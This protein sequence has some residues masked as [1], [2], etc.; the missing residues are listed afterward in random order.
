MKHQRPLYSK[1]SCDDKL[2]IY[3]N[4]YLPKNNYEYRKIL[5]NVKSKYMDD[6]NTSKK[7][8]KYSEEKKFNSLLTN[9]YQDYNILKTKYNFADEDNEEQN[10]YNITDEEYLNKR[11]NVEKIF[12][13]D[14]F[15]IQDINFDVTDNLLMEL[16]K[17]NNYSLIK[18]TQIK[19]D[20]DFRLQGFNK[21]NKYFVPNE[22]KIVDEENDNENEFDENN[23][24][25][26]IN[27]NHVNNN[28]YEDQDKVNI[29]AENNINNNNNEIII[30]N[31]ND[32]ISENNNNI[33][34]N[35]SEEEKSIDYLDNDEQFNLKNNENYLILNQPNKNGDLPLFSDIISSDYYD[36]YR[37]PFYE[38]PEN[39]V[40]EE[41]N[42]VK[43]KEEENSELDLKKTQKMEKYLIKTIPDDKNV[44]ILE[45]KNEENLKFEDIIDGNF[46]GNYIIPEYIIPNDIKK[47]MEEEQKKEQENKNI[48]NEN[49][50]VDYN[51]INNNNNEYEE[52]NNMNSNNLPVMNDLIKSDNEENKV[53]ND[54]MEQN[55][56]ENKLQ[57]NNDNN[58]E[59]ENNDNNMIE[60]EIKDAEKKEEKIVNKEPE[61]IEKERES[62]IDEDDQFEKIDVDNL[63][64]DDDKKYDDFEA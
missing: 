60:P 23:N 19:E 43:P 63:D 24:N 38:N 55:N 32:N 47:E 9:Y 8:S 29:K 46:Q 11:Q 21:N 40:A 45:N 1:Y 44:I 5:S 53:N 54:N 61:K 28:E 14:L 18:N 30:D 50:K 42:V 57:E 2:G 62:Y 64:E 36:N 17:D 3:S 20:Y 6:Y 49:A 33:N 10:D 59:Q 15:D 35:I 51:N 27:I 13:G 31:N 48:Y 25:I 58:K 12:S 7:F 16:P 26:N 56:D 22:E 52:K 39:I 37:V 41:E 4:P 34:N